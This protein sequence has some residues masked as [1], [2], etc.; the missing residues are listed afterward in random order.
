M[1]DR[2]DIISFYKKS[3]LRIIIIMAILLIPFFLYAN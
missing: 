3:F 1:Q 2:K